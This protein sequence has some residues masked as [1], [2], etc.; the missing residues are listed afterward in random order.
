M[1]C[2]GGAV[3]CPYL[4]LVFLGQLELC[5]LAFR[6]F[7]VQGLLHSPLTVDLEAL[8]SGLNPLGGERAADGDCA[9]CAPALQV[10]VK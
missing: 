4:L 1:I 6:E 2:V 5:P 10:F 7:G 9:S 8:Q 3:P